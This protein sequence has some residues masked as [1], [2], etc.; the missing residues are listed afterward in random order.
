MRII[1]TV[2]SLAL[3]L[4]LAACSLPNDPAADA[5][6]RKAF[7]Q[8]RRGDYAGLMAE[9]EP[10]SFGPDSQPMLVQMHDMLPPGEPTSSRL[11][12]FNSY[13]GTAGSTLTLT[14]V[15][16][17][18]DRRV[19]AATMLV[20]TGS[21]DK[22]SWIIRGFHVNVGLPPP[23]VPTAKTPARKSPALPKT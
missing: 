15:Y 6:A 14:H 7:D 20:K 3:A 22:V 19:T 5:L 21:G 8:L 18:G 1:I 12:G 11:A 23:S 4:A 2:V 17:Y 9:T 16:D 13:A 10:K